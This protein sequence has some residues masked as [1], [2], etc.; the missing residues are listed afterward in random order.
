MVYIENSKIYISIKRKVQLI[1]ECS[2]FIEHH[3]CIMNS[4]EI[5]KVTVSLKSEKILFDRVVDGSLFLRVFNPKYIHI[6]QEEVQVHAN[7]INS[8]V[9][10]LFIAIERE[11]DWFLVV[12]FL[13][14]FF[15]FYNLYLWTNGNFRR[16]LEIDFSVIFLYI[17]RNYH[18]TKL[19]KFIERRAITDDISRAT[20]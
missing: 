15:M 7:R 4:E 14:G 17:D 1:L 8:W 16:V 5:E 19:R 13:V 10:Y 12:L 3:L 11:R 18:E 6:D 9:L 20:G 2:L